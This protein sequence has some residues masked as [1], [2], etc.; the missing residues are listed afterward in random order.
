MVNNTN[1][2][3]VL[4]QMRM[5]ANEAGPEVVPG[6]M[7]DTAVGRG[8]FAQELHNSIE[9]INALQQTAS[10]QVKAFELG[11]PGIELNDV[12]VDMQKATLA[13]EMGVQ[14]RN[15]LVSAYREIMNMP[16]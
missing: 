12:M 16:V 10:S 9:R 15:R 2:Q 11:V 1:M 14:V 13:F 3:A 7:I 4:Q 5:L 8:G 6:Q